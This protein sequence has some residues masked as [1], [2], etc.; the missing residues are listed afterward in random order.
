MEIVILLQ[1]T[2]VG[3][4]ARENFAVDG[5]R[6]VVRCA[7]RM[8]INSPGGQLCKRAVATVLQRYSYRFTALQLPVLADLYATALEQIEPS[9]V[10][11]VRRAMCDVTS[12]DAEWDRAAA[13]AVCERL[14]QGS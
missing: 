4:F 5:G 6:V 9:A 2:P 1:G 12:E 10:Q 8:K 7:Q 13:A 14:S 3:D 11:R